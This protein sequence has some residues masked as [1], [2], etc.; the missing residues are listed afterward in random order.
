MLGGVLD[1]LLGGRRNASGAGR[2]VRRIIPLP[3]VMLF[4]GHPILVPE[5]RSQR[6]VERHL[7]PRPRP[8]TAEGLDLFAVCHLQRRRTII[9]PTVLLPQLHIAEH[10]RMTVQ[11]M[12][13]HRTL[14]PN[15]P[16]KQVIR[17][18]VEFHAPVRHVCRL[19]VA[20]WV[21]GAHPRSFVYPATFHYARAKCVFRYSTVV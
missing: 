18:V 8:T 16:N 11:G 17:L 4:V 13:G 9:R 6:W 15:D 7:H 2:G 1:G 21:D 14:L 12:V 5:L 3:T 20:D 10:Q 19:H